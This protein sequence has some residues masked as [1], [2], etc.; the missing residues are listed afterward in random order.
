MR[1]INKHRASDTLERTVA[2]LW[3]LQPSTAAISTDGQ[4]GHHTT[5]LID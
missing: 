5:L 3:C 1:V 4:D 2:T